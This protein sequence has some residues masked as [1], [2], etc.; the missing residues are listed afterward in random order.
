MFRFE[1]PQYLWLLLL[2]AVLAI[3]RLF[4]LRS[5]RKAYKRIG[6]PQLVRQMTP[7]LSNKRTLLKFILLLAGIFFLIIALARP[8]LGSKFSREKRNGIEIMIALDVSNSMNATDVKPSRLEKSKLLIENLLDNFTTDKLGMIVFA[9]K[10]Y[11]QLPMT[12]DFVSARMLLSESS[13]QMIPVQGTD[14]AAAID[15]AMQCFSTNTT[16]GKAIVLITDGENHEGEAEKMAKK[17]KRAGINVFILGVGSEQGA[18]IPVEGG[19]YMAD[20]QGNTVVTR[21]NTAMCQAVATAGN[22]RYIHV[23]NTRQ[24]QE[25]LNNDLER[26]QHGET[27]SVVYSEYAEQFPLFVILS[28]ACFLAEMFVWEMRNPLLRRIKVFDKKK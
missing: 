25:R 1:S 9:G 14:I 27:E 10:A 5:K 3:V 11:V 26:L 4:V 15:M 17:A 13:P 19:G 21:L 23:D 16:I 18:P 2:L 20:R 12:N 8:Q 24:A 7:M 28:L 22:G 6:D